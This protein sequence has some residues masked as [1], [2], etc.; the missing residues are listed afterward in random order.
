MA[1]LKKLS[2]CIGE[3]QLVVP[4]PQTLESLKEIETWLKEIIS[5]TEQAVIRYETRL[6]RTIP[7]NK[8]VH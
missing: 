3:M 2:H 1:A 6:D 8:A 5:D 4:P 7:Q